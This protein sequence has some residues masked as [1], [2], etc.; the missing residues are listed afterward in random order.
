M[1]SVAHFMI[2]FPYNGSAIP[3]GKEKTLKL[4]HW[5]NNGWE[6]CTILLDKDNNKITGR[7]TSLSPF[8][9][10]YSTSGSGSSDNGSSSSSY[11]TGANENMIALIAI[12][13]ILAGVFLLRKR[14]IHAR[15]MDK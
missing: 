11:S 4:F 1:I 8:G 7:V 14:R 10:G 15:Q 9:M 12:L 3:S 2:T 13:A 5:K 6:D